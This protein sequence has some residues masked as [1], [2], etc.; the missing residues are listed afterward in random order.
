MLREVS[1]EI[2]RRCPNNCV[3]CSSLSNERCSEIL[4]YERFVS[5][6]DDAAYLGAKIICL[7]GGEP[8]LHP[9]IVE[10]VKYVHSL[11][12]DSYVYTSGIIFDADGRKAPLDRDVLRAIA[13]KVTKLIFN[14]EAGTQDTYDMVM[15]TRGCFE[16]MKQSVIMANE[17]SILTEAHFVP[18]KLNIHE[19][20]KA[21]S[22]CSELNISKVSFLRLVLHGRA[23][24]NEQRIALSEEEFKQLQADLKELKK[25]S[26]VNIRIGVPLSTEESCHKCEAA[27][28]KLNIRYDGNVFPCEVFKNDRMSHRL[29]GLA[30][31]SIHSSSLLDI[32]QNSKYLQRVRKLS[33]EFSCKEHYETCIGQYLI[34]NCEE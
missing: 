11:G 17:L 30:T 31:D 7:S 14:I 13:G 3:H 33:Q 23:Q 15:G 27:N 10:M 12:L 26:N 34:N 32:F 2:I 4:N 8:F 19:V 25:K 22:L 28:G 29:K 6:V 24:E 21:V 5:V 1:I 18:M 16:K 9:E 20:E